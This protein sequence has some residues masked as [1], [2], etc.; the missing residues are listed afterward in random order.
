MTMA[1]MLLILPGTSQ[2]TDPYKRPPELARAAAQRE[3]RNARIEWTVD[4]LDEEKPKE[5]G[6]PRDPIGVL[7]K[8]V[9]FLNSQLSKGHLGQLAIEFSEHVS[10]NRDEM[11]EYV[12]ETL[13]FLSGAKDE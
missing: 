6:Y 13:E 4:V 9:E 11:Q 8:Y 7:A 2:D 10:W 1:L 5:W 3:W 12:T